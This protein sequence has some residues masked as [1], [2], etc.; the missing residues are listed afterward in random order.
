M[1]TIDLVN[2]PF[3]GFYSQEEIDDMCWILDVYLNTYTEV[4]TKGSAYKLAERQLK[5]LKEYHSNET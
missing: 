3:L 2:A 4:S 5:Y 1:H